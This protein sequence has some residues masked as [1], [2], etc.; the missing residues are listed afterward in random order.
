MV[1]DGAGG[2]GWCCVTAILNR[3]MR[4]WN[5]G[6][7]TCRMSIYLNSQER[8]TRPAQRE[9]DS[10]N[11]RES[12][13]FEGFEKFGGFE[14]FEGCEKLKFCRFSFGSLATPL[15]PLCCLCRH[16]F[17]FITSQT[18]ASGGE[19][20]EKRGDTEWGAR[21]SHKRRY[22][23]DIELVSFRW[24]EINLVSCFYNYFAFIQP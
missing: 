14:Q 13:G 8:Y 21:E 19:W 6:S 15:R 4:R 17:V 18:K 5:D 24:S 9:F 11:S 10:R 7:R 2:A 1:L 23:K 22:N 12:R 16:I 3:W 20:K